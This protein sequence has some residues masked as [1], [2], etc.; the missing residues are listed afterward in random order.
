MSQ[1]GMFQLTE[2]DQ[3]L[4]LQIARNSVQAHLTG[5]KLELPEIF[6]GVLSEFRGNFVSLHKQLELRGCIGNLYP[7]GPLYRS[8]SEC[9]ISAATRDPRFPRLGIEELPE[10]DF[11][12]SVLSSMERVRDIAEIEIG[13][14]GLLISR[15]DRR[16]LLLPQVAAAFGWD[17]I[18]FLQETCKKAGLKPDDWESADIHCFSAVVFR[19]Q[20]FHF[21]AVS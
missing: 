3:K 9:S 12:I 14:H 19:E 17:R 8:V 16:G 5:E 10:V 20:Q 18:T 2:T 15:S 21:T 13:K 4:L 7:T 6:C 11:E 1:L